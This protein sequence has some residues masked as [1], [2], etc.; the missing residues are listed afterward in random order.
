MF[1][2]LIIVS[3]IYARFRG[4]RERIVIARRPF[5]QFRDQ[6]SDI[7][8]VTYEIVVNDED[9]TTPPNPHQR[10]QLGENL[11]ITLRAWDATID[12]DDVAELTIEWTAARVL[13]G[14]VAVLL[15]FGQ[16]EI[17]NGR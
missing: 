16:R 6:R 13:H 17:R 15:K 5:G 3:E 4:K 7:L 2:Q 10:V 11:L 12:L 14:H 9:L 1:Q 8:F